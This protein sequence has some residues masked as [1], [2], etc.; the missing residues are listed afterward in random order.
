MDIASTRLRI[1]TTQEDRLTRL[2]HA[3]YECDPIRRAG[4]RV[5]AVAEIARAALEIGIEALEDR[6]G[7]ADPARRLHNQGD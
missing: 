5:P 1:T 2:T 4:G 3:A 7:L 6:Y